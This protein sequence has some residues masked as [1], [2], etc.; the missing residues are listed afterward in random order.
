MAFLKPLFNLP[1]PPLESHPGG[2]IVCTLP[3]PRVYVLTWSS[4]PDNRLTP[5]F[6]STLLLALDIIE[7]KYE[8]GV[9]VTTSALPKFY[10]N[11]ADLS[12]PMR[13][14]TFWEKH[15][16]P[17]LRRLIT[18]PMPTVALVNGHAFAGGIMLAMH[19]DY[20]VFNDAK[21]YLCVNELQFGAPIP[22]PLTNIFKTKVSGQAYRKLVLEAHRFGAKEALEAGIVDEVGDLNAA[23]VFIKRLGLQDK[24]SAPLFLQ[25]SKD[26]GSSYGLLKEEMYRDQIVLLDSTTADTWK[27][28]E[29]LVAESKRRARVKKRV[30][31]WE[32]SNENDKSKL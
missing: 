9:V 20:R 32:S 17:V 10:S 23:L 21:G 16:Y 24:A 27:L 6:L 15:F 14:P 22:P 2:T 5:A 26:V 30:Q 11:G 8:R 1:I 28:E 19:H 29:T 31:E 12:F 4:P 13:D 7:A 3:A 25:A 18:Y